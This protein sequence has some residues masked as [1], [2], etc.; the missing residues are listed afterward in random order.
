MYRQWVTCDCNFSY[1]FKPIFWNFAH[2]FSWVCRSA[3]GLDLIFMTFSTLTLSFSY[4]R[5]YEH[6]M[7]VQTVGT[8]WAK[9][10]MHHM[11]KCI[12]FWWNLYIN[13]FYL[14]NKHYF[15]CVCVGGGGGGVL[16]VQCNI[17][18]QSSSYFFMSHIQPDSHTYSDF[19]MMD[20]AWAQVSSLDW[21][22][23]CYFCK[24]ITYPYRIYN[25][26]R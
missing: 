10:L 22:R 16:W 1:N 12:C 19:D 13:F 24:L 8:F 3:C 25:D 7:S 6:F 14:K 18:H 9:L 5:F 4:L 20:K 21:K 11:R 26:S 17:N 2:I 23:S 15:V